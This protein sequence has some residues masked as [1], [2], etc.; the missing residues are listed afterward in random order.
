MFNANTKCEENENFNAF[1]RLN[2]GNIHY[3]CL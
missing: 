2:N 1:I 3:L